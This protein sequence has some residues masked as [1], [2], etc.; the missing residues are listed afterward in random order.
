MAKF[1]K[2]TAAILAVGAVAAG[3]A[4]YYKKTKDEELEDDFDDDFEDFDDDE[5]D[6]ETVKEEPTG[7][8][9]CEC[10]CESKDEEQPKAEFSEKPEESSDKPNDIWYQD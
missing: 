7:T 1:K 8:K 3:A 2:L 5:D 9:E 6:D 10:G 4:Y